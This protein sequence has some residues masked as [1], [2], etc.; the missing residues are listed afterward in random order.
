MA[1]RVHDDIGGVRTPPRALP[2]P[3]QL[4]A[5]GA[6]LCLY[7]AQSG[8]ELTGW[9]QA[10]RAESHSVLDSDGLREHLVFRDR[11]G[12]CCWRLSLLPDSDFL[13]WERLTA[14][15]PTQA[16]AVRAAGIGERLWW[17]LA[18][19]LRGD[20]WQACVLRLHALR[21]SPGF[22]LREQP[23]LAA[24]LAAPSP[25]GAATARRL[26]RDEGA[27]SEALTDDCCCRQ[28]ALAAAQVASTPAWH[29]DEVFPLIR[30]NLGA[31]T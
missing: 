17:R 11:D 9:A 30:L 19:R 13:A 24:S 31:S 4:A 22:G 27:D 29:G 2:S 23:V 1:A 25:L 12:R 20:R 18:D 7:R 6:V 26:A 16:D 3:S 8:G 21:C 28:A 10:T 15:L 5:L 14:T